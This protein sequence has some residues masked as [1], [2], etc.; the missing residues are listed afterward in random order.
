VTGSGAAEAAEVVAT[1][2]AVPTAVPA[3]AAVAVA[4][5]A[6][7]VAVVVAVVVW[8]ESFGVDPSVIVVLPWHVARSGA[9]ARVSAAVRC[10]SI[11][12]VATRYP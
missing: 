6:V 4:V 11:C 8:P 7:A 1:V 3:V 5:A 9:Q 12:R 2:S 10:G